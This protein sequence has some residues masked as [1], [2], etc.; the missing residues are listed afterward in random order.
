MAENNLYRSCIIKKLFKIL[1]EQ[2]IQEIGAQRII[3]PAS[4]VQRGVYE[5]FGI[6]VSR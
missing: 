3:Y 5:A 4:K 1:V 6:E 2:R